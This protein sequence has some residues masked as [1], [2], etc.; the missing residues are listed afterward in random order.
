MIYAPT[1]AVVA[2]LTAGEKAT[3]RGRT[4]TLATLVKNS[5]FGQRVSDLL[6][7]SKSVHVSPTKEHDDDDN[8]QQNFRRAA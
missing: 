4:G 8:F 5:Q 2:N 6:C 7:M 1:C 3:E